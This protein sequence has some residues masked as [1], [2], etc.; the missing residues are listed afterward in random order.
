MYIAVTRSTAASRLAKELVP[1]Q[2]TVLQEFTFFFSK[3]F[4]VVLLFSKEK[5]LI[6]TVTRVLT[7]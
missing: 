3:M 1:A 4:L 7:F 2:N 5:C 6:L